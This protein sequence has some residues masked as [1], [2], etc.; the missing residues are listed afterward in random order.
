MMNIRDKYLDKKKKAANACGILSSGKV[1]ARVSEQVERH[2][3]LKPQDDDT[4]K[5]IGNCIEMKKRLLNI[6]KQFENSGDENTNKVISE[7]KALEINNLSDCK[8]LGELYTKVGKK[9]A[10]QDNVNSLMMPISHNSRINVLEFLFLAIV[11]LLIYLML[12]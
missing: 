7:I 5:F 1:I 10:K 11:G 6:I 4:D 2:K 3:N 9:I 8:K 12:K